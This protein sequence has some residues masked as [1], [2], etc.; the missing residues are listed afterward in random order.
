MISFLS[1]WRRL[2]PRDRPRPPQ[3]LQRD[4]L[5]Q[6]L[7]Q[8]R[9]RCSHRKYRPLDK[10]FSSNRIVDTS[11][12]LAKKHFVKSILVITYYYL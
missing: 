5:V 3:P 2:R 8:C 10:S 11:S 9:P 4:N 12:K 1:A 6:H 7:P